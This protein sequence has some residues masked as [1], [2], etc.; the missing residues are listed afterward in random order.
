MLFTNFI[1]LLS[2]FKPIY[3]FECTIKTYNCQ[4]SDWMENSFRNVYFGCLQQDSQIQS[5]DFNDINISTSYERFELHFENKNYD[6]IKN[7][8][9]NDKIRRIRMRNNGL[10]FIS[11]QTFVG[12]KNVEFIYLDLNQIEYVEQNSFLNCSSL[13]EINLSYNMIKRVE[14]NTFLGAHSL[15]YLWLKKNKIITIE[16]DSLNH[17]RLLKKISL[18]KNLIENTPVELLTNLGDLEEIYL[19]ENTISTLQKDSFRDT[20]SLKRQAKFIIKLALF[21]GR[22][23]VSVRSHKVF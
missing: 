10:K 23:F 13:Y 14:S 11:N 4:C 5:F 15:I 7:L 2:L 9:F 17:L 22:G 19:S 3:F 16:I 18:D 8:K 12:M 21:I 20:K 1:F 6:L